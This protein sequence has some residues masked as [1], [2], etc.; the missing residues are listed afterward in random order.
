L[1]GTLSAEPSSHDIAQVT[2]VRGGARAVDFDRSGGFSIDSV[3]NSGTNRFPGELTWQLSTS[4]MVAALQRT[5]ASRYEQDR[6]WFT[7]NAGGPVIPNKL[8]FYGSYYRPQNASHKRAQQN[9]GHPN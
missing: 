3:S 7:V 2:T 6:S 8:N 4:K 5:S 1:F 9:E